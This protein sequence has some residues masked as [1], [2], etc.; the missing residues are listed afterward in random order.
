MKT[1]FY[2]KLAL[3]GMRKNRRL[4]LPYILSCIGMVMMYYI[5]HALSL[6]EVLKNAKGAATVGTTL[7]LGKFVVAAFSVLFLFYTN[8]FLT[9]RRY[10]EFGL[11][12]I[13][14]MDKRKIGRVVFFESLF[15]A[16]AALA[17]GIGLGIAFSKYAELGLLNAASID[18]DYCFR[19]P[20]KAIT[21]ALVLYGIIFLLL[22]GKSLWQVRRQN[23]LELL[24]SEN[25]GEK[26]PKGNL[27]IGLLG[28]ALLVAAYVIAVSI[29]SPLSALT[30]FFVAVLMVIVATYLLF[31][32]G[33]VALCRL[34]KKSKK[35]YYKKQH[36]VSVS[37][38]AYR[39]KRNGAGLASICILATMV[40]VMI[41]S[42]ASL[43]F[44]KDQSI[45]ST[46]PRDCEIDVDL[47]TLAH[48]NDDVIPELRA[49]YEKS[50]ADNG[51]TPKNLYETRYAYIAALQEGASFNPNAAFAGPSFNFDDVRQLVFIS[52][53]D[54]EKLTGEAVSLNGNE[55]L[56]CADRCR[57]TYQ[58]LT[59][60][61]VP[62]KITG[63][64]K[65]NPIK[66]ESE[67]F[68]VPTLAVIVSDYD[69][70][71]PFDKP[72]DS[73][74]FAM[75]FAMMTFRYAYAYD[76]GLPDEEAEEIF[77]DQYDAMNNVFENRS[78]F[79]GWGSYSGCVATARADFYGAYGSLFFLGIILSVVFIF[80]AAMI[81]YYKQISE[82]YEDKSRF[83]IMQKVGMTKADIKKSINSQVL[84]VFFAPLLLA[85]L[86]LAF[87]FPLVW[88]IL[89]MFSL[90]NLWFVIGVTVL[91]F[92]LFAAF[93]CLIYKLTARAYYKIVAE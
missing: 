40:L 33:S 10:K 32:S 28:L 81:I 19:V 29:K 43:Y 83:D 2:P 70:L 67:A 39:M 25:A 84:T 5:L 1:L 88:K 87:A 64:I 61:G 59:L 44:G 73:Y 30:V 24:R 89:Q 57:Y 74:A 58:T 63:H 35:Y 31:I 66:T 56:L 52:A 80:A 17:G 9:R 37:S 69:V 77:A 55:V 6:S 60:D 62:L 86:H 21:D 65:E 27:I 8:S 18:I 13:L 85:G 7:G 46:Y 42:S 34:L 4:Y 82:G 90:T 48:F 22:M 23:P 12:S 53:E 79:D 20:V 16:V 71:A 38:M 92:L 91:A 50:F 51:F 36:F 78:D 11:Y 93:Y 72:E 3:T 54:Y 76:T 45:R 41:S 14:G 26:P 47:K 75:I 49:A 68:F 15:V